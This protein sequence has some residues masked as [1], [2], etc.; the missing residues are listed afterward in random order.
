MVKIYF[1]D[2]KDKRIR[3]MLNLIEK[4]KP[5][6]ADAIVWLQGDRYDRS[7]KVLSLFRKGWANKI[8]VSGNNELIGPDKKEGEKNI[9]LIEMVNW[10]KKRGVKTSQILIES[11]SFN[12]EDQAKNILRLSQKMGWEKIILVTSLYHQLRVFLTF[13]KKAQ[14]IG[15]KGI[16]IN[17]PVKINWNKIP[18]GRKKKCKE[19]FKE[20]LKKIKKYRDNMATIR[21]GLSY[22]K[23]K[24][25]QRK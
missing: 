19:L 17:Q 16:L 5:Q 7:K 25:C 15:W 11:E 24:L 13:L 21:E 22:L 18:G 23:N 14:K 9:S 3:E 12:T 6:K 20:E 8:I 4:E 2:L 10:L 1:R